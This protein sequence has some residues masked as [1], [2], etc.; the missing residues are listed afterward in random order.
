MKI[1]NIVCTA[2]VLLLSLLGP[3]CAFAHNG[4][5]HVMGTVSAVTSGSITVDTVKHTKV[6]VLI[7]QSTKFANGSVTASLKD[8]KL[9]DRVVIHAKENADKKLVAA[10][11][12]W[13]AGPSQ[14]G[15]MG[16]MDHEH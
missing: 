15:K 4:M 11:V 13:G 12:K 10:E 9:G 6:T 3:I 2:A 14:S 5:E 7:D 16:D 8:L 1:R